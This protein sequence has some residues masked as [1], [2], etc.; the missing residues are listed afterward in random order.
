MYFVYILY[1]KTKDRYY[2]GQ[3]D[4]IENRMEY[5]NSGESPYTSI[6]SDWV[7]VYTEEYETRTGARKLEN[8][9]KR[10]KSRKYIEW[11]MSASSRQRSG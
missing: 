6:A 11:L 7:V 5:H 10:K 2:V 4:N 3:T 9:I 8:E 1:S